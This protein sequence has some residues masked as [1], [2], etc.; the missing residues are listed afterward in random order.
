MLQLLHSLFV[1]PARARLRS[2]L[3]GTIL[4]SAIAGSGRPVLSQTDYYN[5]DA[6]RPMQ[7]E[8]ASPV[9][10]RAFEI[11]AAPLRFER[12]GS[13]AYRWE[14]EPE[15]AYGIFPRTHVE[16][17]APFALAVIDAD[18]EK[19]AGLSGIHISAF[20]NLNSETS[21]PALAIAAGVL[22]PVGLLAPDNAYFSVKGVLTRTFTWARFHVNGEYTFG[23]RLAPGDVESA[24]AAELSS[25]LGGVAVDRAFPLEALLV[26][27]EVYARESLHQGEALQWNTGVGLRYQLDPRVNIDGGIG[28]RL[29]GDDRGWYITFGSAY[30]VGLPWNR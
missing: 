22:L 5:T 30:A 14:I 7:I 11:Q 16:L 15:V 2:V 25:W 23:S 6:G 18:G 20:H 10:R 3:I 19:D 12:S 4:L 26:S 28:R 1:S 29:T 21:I 9:E 13:G 24:G 17:G 27:G 8:D